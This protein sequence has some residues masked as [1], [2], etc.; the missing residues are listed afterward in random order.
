[1][2]KTKLF[3]LNLPFLPGLPARTERAICVS[4]SEVTTK[5]LVVKPLSRLLTLSVAK[6]PPECE[7]I[8]TLV[9]LKS[10]D[11]SLK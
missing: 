11:V 4:H 1:M 8:S 7:I 6:V 2:V 10:Y 5:R 9:L 3:R